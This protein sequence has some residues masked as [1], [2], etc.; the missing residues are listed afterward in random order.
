MQVTQQHLQGKIDH[1]HKAIQN[2]AQLKVDTCDFILIIPN[3]NVDQYLIRFLYD[4]YRSLF[5]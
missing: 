4:L 5:C 1:L 3:R 2:T